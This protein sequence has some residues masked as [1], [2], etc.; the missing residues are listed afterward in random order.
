MPQNF[1]LANTWNDSLV[2]QEDRVHIEIQHSDPLSIRIEIIAPYYNNPPP[3]N[4]PGRQDKLWEYDVVEIFFVGS[5]GRY[6][7]TEFGPHGHYLILELSGPREIVC[8]DLTCRYQ[9]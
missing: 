3:S 6:I 2:S 9:S 1:T 4:T 8:K 7:E 5:D